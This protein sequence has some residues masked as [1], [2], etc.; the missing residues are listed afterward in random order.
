MRLNR[1]LFLEQVGACG[2]LSLGAAPPALLS[3]MA[4][5]GEGS[6]GDR[7]LVVVELA[8]GND[9]LTTVTPYGADV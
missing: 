9:G 2:L 3:R 7:V 4:R 6:T 8:G 1:R 5:A